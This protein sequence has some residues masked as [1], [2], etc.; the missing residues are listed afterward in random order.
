MT[1]FSDGQILLASQLTEMQEATSAALAAAAAAS[2]AASDHAARNDNP[3]AVTA[4]QTNFNPAGTG[5]VGRSTEAKLREVSVSVKDFGAVGDG[6]TNDSAAWQAA[7]NSVASGSVVRI[8]V[9]GADGNSTN[10][11]Y[12][13][14]SAIAANGRIPFFDLEPG[15]SVVGGVPPK[16]SWPAR[17]TEVGATGVRHDYSAQGVS[18]SLGSA[19]HE[20]VEMG[21]AGTTTPGYGIRWNYNSG[22]YGAGF[23]ISHGIVGVWARNS[24]QDGG[25]NLT[26]WLLSISPEAAGGT[27]RWGQFATE[28]NV[29]N[30]GGDTG[31]AK[32]RAL[33]N[34]WS[35]VIQLVVEGGLFSQSGSSYNALYHCVVAPSSGNKTDGIPGQSYNGFL[36]EPNAIAGNGYGG[37]WSGNDSGVSARDPKA[38]LALDDTWQGGFRTNKA[39]L[40]TGVA[41][42]LGAT[43]AVAWADTAD[44]V[45]NGIYSGTGAPEAVTTAGIGSLDLRRDGAAGRTLYVKEAGTGNTGWTA[46]LTA[47]LATGLSAAGTTQGTATALTKRVNVVATAAA[48]SGVI[49][50]ASLPDEQIIINRGANTV[51]VYPPVGGQID[52]LGVNVAATVASSAKLRVV[53]ASATQWY[54]V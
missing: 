24:G 18:A 12:V 33:L 28:M 32:K 27:T 7:V 43:Q 26:Q 17:W 41:F 34:N 50:S 44:V 23:D 36:I 16:I 5:A 6:V 22:A 49:L 35:G 11:S 14:T 54:S 13:L 39:T 29:V 15:A 20:F 10:K 9:P 30:R 45:S 19:S 48:S 2:Q 38:A 53:Q 42:Q 31:W 1:T 8:K 52:A 46:A 4:A 51:N 40:T 47:S 37:Y 25:Q 21:R 3:H